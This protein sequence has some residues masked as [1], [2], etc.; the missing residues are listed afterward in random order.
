MSGASNFPL[1][2]DGI[3]ENLFYYLWCKD[4][5]DNGPKIN[6]PDTIVYK[7]RQPACW[8]FTAKDGT[9]KKKHK[10]NLV[11]VRIEESFTQKT[12]GSDIIAYYIS[13]AEGEDGNPLT[14]IEYFNQESFHEFLYNRE[15]VNNGI[16]QKFIEPKGVQNSMVR[17]IWSPKVCLLERRINN[18]NLQDRRFGMYERAVTYEGAEFYSQAAP[19]RGALLPGQV[20]AV[21]ENIVA[22]V[23]EVSFQKYKISRMVTNFKVDANGEVWLLWSSS[24]RLE[25]ETFASKGSD[26]IP[27][28]PL[29]I[30]TVIRLPRHVRLGGKNFKGTTYKC[31]ACG[32]MK[33]TEQKY[34]VPYKTVIVHFEQLL[35]LLQRE[36]KIRQELTGNTSL[37]IEWPPAPE[38]VQAWGGGSSVGFPAVEEDSNE[39][40]M[41]APT[42][43]EVEIPP[44]LRALHPKLS[45]FDYRRYKSD[46]L[47]MYKQVTCCED[48]ILVYAEVM[49]SSSIESLPTAPGVFDGGSIGDRASLRRQQLDPLGT[50]ELSFMQSRP[51][52]AGAS[53]QKKTQRLPPE[54]WEL[55]MSKMTGS[56]GKSR[57]QKQG[58]N[59]S[60]VMGQGPPSFP[61]RIETRMHAQSIMDATRD[62]Q[63]RSADLDEMEWLGLQETQS[64]SRAGEAAAAAGGGDGE[65]A[66][67]YAG[68]GVRAP[69]LPSLQEREEA[70]FKDLYHNPNLQSGH[71]LAHLNASYSKLE[72]AD[73]T[74]QTKSAPDFQAPSA[75]RGGPTRSRSVGGAGGYNPYAVTQK[76]HDAGKA[77]RGSRRSKGAAANSA[78]AR[79]AGQIKSQGEAAP[80]AEIQFNPKRKGGK[81]GGSAA[82]LNSKSADLHRNFLLSTLQGVRESLANPPPLLDEPDPPSSYGA[83]PSY[84]EFKDG[85]GARESKDAGGGFG[86]DSWA[87]ASL[88]PAEPKGAQGSR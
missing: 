51:G 61:G 68:S 62:Q 35:C 60:N 88:A 42:A 57:T 47:F 29:N 82:M 77:S 8:Y 10:G 55:E 49:N 64:Q 21:C 54:T 59:S 70:F 33:P 11:N 30:D 9:I 40:H 13:T 63:D 58:L 41:G 7:F 67:P 37:E 26:A 23:G 22:H 28:G 83:P 1:E 2:G 78:K 32:L 19:V 56:A 12:T 72:L 73:S 86:E 79:A 84:E 43:E 69:Q 80:T 74:A 50:Q 75:G 48:C 39:E 27:K 31:V 45:V 20:Q 17:S 5:L 52:G 46:P 34:P 53:R 38:V 4:E 87:G 36:L 3:I 14:T 25:G 15:K 76:L 6:I 44:V 66:D 65:E 81:K 24:L 85:G 71:P 16:V 18:R